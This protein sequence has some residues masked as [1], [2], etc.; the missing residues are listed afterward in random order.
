MA[1]DLVKETAQKEGENG[2]GAMADDE[3]GVQRYAR[4]KDSQMI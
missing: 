2:D 4:R 1:E 3:D